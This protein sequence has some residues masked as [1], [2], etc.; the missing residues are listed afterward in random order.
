MG[1]PINKIQQNRRQ[2]MAHRLKILV[3]KY[4]LLQR[5]DAERHQQNLSRYETHLRATSSFSATL[6]MRT[7]EGVDSHSA[8]V[9][10]H[11]AHREVDTTAGR[12]PQ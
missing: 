3:A 10:A 9:M 1:T 5:Q 11:A 6:D 8:W 7:G 2:A 4:Q 12:H